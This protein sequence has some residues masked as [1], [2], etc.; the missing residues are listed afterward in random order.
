LPKKCFPIFIDQAKSIEIEAIVQDLLPQIITEPRVVIHINPEQMEGINEKMGNLSDRVHFEGKLI[1]QE[2]NKIN[3]GDVNVDWSN[4]RA[5]RNIDDIWQQV[6]TIVEQ[7]ILR[8]LDL[9]EFPESESIE[10]ELEIEALEPVLDPQTDENEL[11]EEDINPETDLPLSDKQNEIE[12][13]PEPEQ[14]KAEESVD[15]TVD[16]TA[17]VDSEKIIDDTMPSLEDLPDEVNDILSDA[18]VN[19]AEMN[20]DGAG[21]EAVEETS[22]D[23]ILE[24]EET[25]AQPADQTDDPAEAEHEENTD[26]ELNETPQGEDT[27]PAG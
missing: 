18:M 5:E 11:P 26:T 9:P 22:E 24:T 16:S 12:N 8:K 14:E 1:V 3:P 23:A 2:D 7:H 20:I 15:N 25:E 21:P 27:T 19:I 6:H 17:S 13:Q 4:G 10:P